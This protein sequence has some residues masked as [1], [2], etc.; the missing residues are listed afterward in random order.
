[1]TGLLLNDLT[2]LRLINVLLKDSKPAVPGLYS[3]KSFLYSSISTFADLVGH[4]DMHCPQVMHM[5]NSFGSVV[6]SPLS[7]LV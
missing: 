2:D 5:E 3:K 7:I 6:I 1:V 4:T